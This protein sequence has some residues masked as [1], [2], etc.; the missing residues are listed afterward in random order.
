MKGNSLLA[1]FV[2][3]VS[4]RTPAFQPRR[5]APATSEFDRVDGQSAEPRHSHE[6]SERVDHRLLETGAAAR[7]PDI[8]GEK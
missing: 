4:R 8:E 1:Q 7:D 3:V 6:D 2:A 5:T